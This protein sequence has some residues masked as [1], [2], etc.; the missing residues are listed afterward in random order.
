MSLNFNPW[1]VL[2]AAVS[3]FL[4]GG[5]WYAKPVFGRAWGRANGYTAEQMDAM[6]K[7]GQ[8][9]GAR[10]F[11]V[12]FFFSLIAAAAFGYAMGPSPQLGDAVCH[13]VVIGAAFVATSFGIN[14]QFANRTF[15][16][17]L[18]DGGYHILQ[19]VIFGVV[20]GLWH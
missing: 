8:K 19:F 20:L 12:S 13:G 4:L 14:Y 15:A 5:V 2:V 3:A 6:A 11:G 16:L 1:A 10:V 9:H 17:W 18:I 7:A